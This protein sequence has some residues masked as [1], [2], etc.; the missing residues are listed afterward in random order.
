ME[1]MENSYVFIYGWAIIMI[2]I[3]IIIIPFHANGPLHQSHHGQTK[4][5][6]HQFLYLVRMTNRIPPDGTRNGCQR[7]WA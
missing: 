6:L 5:A 3:I 7:S 1:E 4:K 2:I